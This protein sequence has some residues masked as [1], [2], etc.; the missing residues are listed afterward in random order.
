MQRFAAVWHA[1]PQK[2]VGVL[3]ALLLAAMMAVGSGANFNSTSANTGN[4]VT[5]GNLKHTNTGALL[6]VSKIKPGE[7]KSQGSVT[8]QNTGDIDGVFTLAKTVQADSTAPAN[9]FAGKLRVKIVDTSDG[10]VVYDGVLGSMPAS[11]ARTI[12]P[13]DTRTFTFDVTFPDG[14]TGGADNA[15]KGA[16]VTVDYNWEAVNN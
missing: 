7:T 15:Y 6:N 3:F 5:A 2:M 11:D 16:S 4:V 9:P 12:A 8:I 1:S 13:G 10:Y 14:G